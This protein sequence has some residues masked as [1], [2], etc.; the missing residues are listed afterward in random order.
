LIRPRGAFCTWIAYS[1]SLHT[2]YRRAGD[3]AGRILKGAKP[4]D[5]PL[6]PPAAIRLVINLKAAKAI[7]ITFPP[8]ILTRA[9]GAIE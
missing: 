7:G 9:D 5:L 3:H 6:D 2:L 1:D 4:T 8:A